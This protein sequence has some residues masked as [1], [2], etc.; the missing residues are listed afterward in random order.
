MSGQYEYGLEG[1]RSVWRELA[2]EHLPDLKEA[3]L[4]A[5]SHVDLWH[6]FKVHL[7]DGGISESQRTEV[8]S[9]YDYAW[10]CFALSGN[11]DLAAEVSV[12]FYEDLPAYSAFE[13]QVPLFITTTQFERL[14]QYFRYRLTEEEY[15]LF[16]TRFYE[17]CKK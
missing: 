9:I 6:L 10:W 15:A 2:I 16:R 3:I 8:Q 4:G 13:Q 7:A 1:S 11:E 14:E 12:Y 17:N 5:T